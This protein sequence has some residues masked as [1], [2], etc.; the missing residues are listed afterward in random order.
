MFGIFGSSTNAAASSTTTSDNGTHAR[1]DTANAELVQID[2]DLK[3]GFGLDGSGEVPANGSGVR[4]WLRSIYDKLASTIAVTQSGAWTVQPGNTANTTAWKVD[5]SAVTQPISVG[6][7]PLPTGAA[8]SGNQATG[9]TSLASIDGKITVVNT[10]AVVVSSSVL[11]SGA[12]TAA[13]QTNGTMVTAVNNFP[14]T[15]P[16]SAAALPLPTGAATS[17]AQGTANTSLS[18]I[19]TSVAGVLTVQKQRGATSTS[20][21]PSV[22]SSSS[23]AL[24]ANANRL[25]AIIVNNSA[26]TMYL[27]HGTTASS[28]SFNVLL[29]AGGTYVEDVYTGRIDFILASGSATCAV[30]EVTA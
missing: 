28:T 13:N 12:A 23:T 27:K 21:N 7:L 6:S 10:G 14:A 18:N 26:V 3:T 1:L 19:A 29:A 16:V 17:S 20:T 11:P 9:N 8:T 4:G 30:T 24:A 5:G 22:T 25:E 15:Q 2:N